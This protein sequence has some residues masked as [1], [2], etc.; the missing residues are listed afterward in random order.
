MAIQQRATVSIK[1]NVSRTSAADL[2]DSEARINKTLQLVLGSG[3]G[4]DQANQYWADTRIL[5]DGANETLD[6]NGGGLLDDFGAALV[7]AKIKFIMISSLGKG[8]TTSLLIGAA[9]LPI[10]FFE[11]SAGDRG[12]CP[13]EGVFIEAGGK[14]GYA[15]GAGATDGLKI[16]NGAGAAAAYDIYVIGTAS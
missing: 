16:T 4:D 5:A 2:S 1:L 15:V 10:P 13:P 7:F 8:N 6:F 3:T 12:I 14:S 9:A 11:T